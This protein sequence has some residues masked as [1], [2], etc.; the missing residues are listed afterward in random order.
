MRLFIITLLL[1]IT[2][3]QIGVAQLDGT[4]KVLEIENNNPNLGLKKAE[5]KGL[6]LKIPSSITISKT[7]NLIDSL[8][9][10]QIHMLPNKELVVDLVLSCMLI[11]RR[12]N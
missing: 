5:N 1:V 12:K 8:D 3:S 6:A 10:R 4:S 2:C 7:P 11:I 9:A